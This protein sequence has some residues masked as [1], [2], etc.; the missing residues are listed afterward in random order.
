MVDLI[1]LKELAE[2]EGSPSLEEIGS[3]VQDIFD[4]R[5]REARLFGRPERVLPA[6]IISYPHW[7]SDYKEAAQSC[8]LELPMEDAIDAANGWIEEITSK[9]TGSNPFGA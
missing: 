9:L 7:A 8:G 3:A 6:K 5:M 2:E 1:L 4:T